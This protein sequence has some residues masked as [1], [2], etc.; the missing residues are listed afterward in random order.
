MFIMICLRGSTQLG[1]VNILLISKTFSGCESE[2]IYVI[3]WSCSKNVCMFNLTI[4][5]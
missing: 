5:A 3:K 4:I 2:C 1:F